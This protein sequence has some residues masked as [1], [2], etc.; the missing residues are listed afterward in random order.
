[1][2][3]S[4][5]GLMFAAGIGWALIVLVVGILNMIFEGYGAAYLQQRFTQ[6]LLDPWA[7]GNDV[8]HAVNSPVLV[9]KGP[10]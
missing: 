5:K 3:L 10:R 8:N 4:V 1:M 2:K 7:E 9:G 6:Q